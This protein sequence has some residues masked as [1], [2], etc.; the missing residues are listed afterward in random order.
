MDLES[1]P[2]FGKAQKGEFKRKMRTSQNSGTQFLL[3]L[4]ERRKRF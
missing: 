2:G 1:A 4:S 3:M